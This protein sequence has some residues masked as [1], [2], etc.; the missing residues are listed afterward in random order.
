VSSGSDQLADRLNAFYR[1]SRPPS[2]RKVDMRAPESSGADDESDEP[3]SGIET[4]SDTEEE[5]DDEWNGTYTS[6]TT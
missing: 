1:L 2:T 5:S 4:T 6:F 3:H